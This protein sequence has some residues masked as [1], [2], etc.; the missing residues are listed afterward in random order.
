MLVLYGK[1]A[2]LFLQGGYIIPSEFL[3]CNRVEQLSIFI[4]KFN[5][6]NYC[7]LLPINYLSF[8]QIKKMGFQLFLEIPFNQR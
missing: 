4:S 8:K 3:S 7:P 6:M 2:I 5:P 1:G